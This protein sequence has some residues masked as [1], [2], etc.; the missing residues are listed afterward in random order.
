MTTSQVMNRQ[1][2]NFMGNNPNS[3][4]NFSSVNTGGQQFQQQGQNQNYRQD[5]YQ[6]QQQQ[7]QQNQFQNRLQSQQQQFQQQAT[8]SSSRQTPV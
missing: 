1:N 6:Q 4:Q 3:Y 2:N 8:I 7:V 5:N